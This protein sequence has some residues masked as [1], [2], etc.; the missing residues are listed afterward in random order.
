M[1]NQLPQQ[2]EKIAPEDIINTL[3]SAYKV[4]QGEADQLDDLL[5]HGGHLL[6]KAAQRFTTT[7]LIIG[8]AVIAS[9]GVFA[10][11]KAAERDS[12]DTV[13]QPKPVR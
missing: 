10:A 5:R 1:N 7:Q 12:E 11:A 4:F 3:Q 2:V 13:P 9:V 8:I 6:K